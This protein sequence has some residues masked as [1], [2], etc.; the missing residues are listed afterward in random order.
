MTENAQTIQSQLNATSKEYDSFSRRTN[1]E[2]ASLLKIIRAL[3]EENKNLE[4]LNSSFKGN[5]SESSKTLDET[6][7]KIQLLTTQLQD[8]QSETLKLQTVKS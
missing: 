2:K 1:D 3:Q 8:S 7:K 5:M 6:I 4:T